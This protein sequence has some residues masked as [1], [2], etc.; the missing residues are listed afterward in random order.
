MLRPS[1]KTWSKARRAGRGSPRTS[2]RPKRKS[3]PRASARTHGSGWSKVSP[4]CVPSAGRSGT[5]GQTARARR[6]RSR[7]FP[8]AFG[9]QATAGSAGQ[10]RVGSKRALE[11]SLRKRTR[12]KT[13]ALSATVAPHEVGRVEVAVPKPCHHRLLLPVPLHR[14]VRDLPKLSRRLVEAGDEGGGAEHIQISWKEGADEVA[15]GKDAPHPSLLV[16][17]RKRGKPRVPWEL[18]GLADGGV[19]SSALGSRRPP[20]RS[21]RSR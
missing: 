4:V 17:H 7:A 21:E 2:S 15:L 11:P 9:S 19:P 1:G 16:P 13:S 18:Y 6:R 12:A 8:R 3:L 10:G 20:S 5:S 14:V